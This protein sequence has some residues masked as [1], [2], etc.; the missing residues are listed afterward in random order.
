MGSDQTCL[1]EDITPHDTSMAPSQLLSAIPQWRPCSVIC[2]GLSFGVWVILDF[3]SFHCCS[4]WYHG[5]ILWICVYPS[6]AEGPTIVS[7]DSSWCS[8]KYTCTIEIIINHYSYYY[9][10][11]FYFYYIS[12][13]FVIPP[14]K[15]WFSARNA[16]YEQSPGG[17]RMGSQL[18][19]M[20]CQT[21]DVK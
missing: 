3:L 2:Y 15:T 8:S 18:T 21:K 10:Y 1:S 20:V 13:H 7:Y 9:Y 14:R 17:V 6:P 19:Y 4:P 12:C 5:Q 16:K 11:Y